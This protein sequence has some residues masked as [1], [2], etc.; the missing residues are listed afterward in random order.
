MRKPFGLISDIHLFAWESF[1]TVDS[2]G[3]NSRLKGLLSEV[4]RCAAETKAAGGDVVYCAGDV[5]HE[6]GKVSPLVLNPA[7]DTF[8]E[9]TESGVMI[10]I[11]SGNHDLARRD[12][13][14][15]SS[16]ITALEMPGVAV[17]NEPTLFKQDN[18]Y[19]I[20]WFDKL[21][22]L[23]E[24]IEK[25]P[26]GVTL[27]LH[28]PMNGVIRG[29]PET[30]LDPAWLA[31][32]GFERV[33]SGHYHNHKQFPGEVYSIGAT[34]HNTWSDVGSKAGFLV[35][36]DEVKYFKSRL[37]EFLDLDQLALG[38]YEYEEIKLMVDGNYVRI[39]SEES[40]N[41]E[42]EKL[43]EELREWGAK[44]ILIR[45][46]P[47]GS[48]SRSSSVAASISGGASIQQSVTEYVKTQKFQHEALV[49]AACV[50]VLN[51]AGVL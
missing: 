30:G 47:K 50:E 41:S 44:G 21:A 49:S 40:S 6:R 36:G 14:R 39:K 13:E 33:F 38:D 18:V 24:Q 22:D 35:V 25:A 43:R 29:L 2:D 28:A 4:K 31:K 23:K 9:I 37:P 27:I 11:I 46:N 34:A 26:K 48:T 10:R 8:Q 15:L 12:S 3:V 45:P 19:M 16:A 7:I 1:G 20:P 32:L 42:T 5:F 51:Q 17:I